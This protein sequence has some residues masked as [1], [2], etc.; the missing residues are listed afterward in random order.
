MHL[1]R[2]LNFIAV[3]ARRR[4]GTSLTLP[5]ISR[6]QCLS[7]L[8]SVAGYCP[9]PRAATRRP[10]A[11][12]DRQRCGCCLVR[13]N[14]RS[15]AASRTRPVPATK[16]EQPVVSQPVPSP[17]PAPRP[18]LQAAPALRGPSVPVVAPVE[19]GAASAVPRAGN[20]RRGDHG[21]LG[22]RPTEQRVAAYGRRLGQRRDPNKMID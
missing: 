20:R 2:F 21:G 12:G 22:Q 1:L 3:P 14:R 13:H 16:L 8:A 19:G 10:A 4:P 9:V 7:A 17:A 15:T 11:D 6:S 18:A 5:T